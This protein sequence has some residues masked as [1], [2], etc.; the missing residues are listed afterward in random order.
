MQDATMSVN[1]NRSKNELYS[2]EVMGGP[3]GQNIVA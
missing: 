1:L 2:V 3:Q